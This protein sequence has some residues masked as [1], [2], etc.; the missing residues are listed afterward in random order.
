MRHRH[1]NF[2]KKLLVWLLCFKPEYRSKE[3]DFPGGPVIKNL[4]VKERETGLIPGP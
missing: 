3:G 2:F 1:L 4:P